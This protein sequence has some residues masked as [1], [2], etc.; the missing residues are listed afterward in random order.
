MI[1]IFLNMEGFETQEPFMQKRI[2]LEH[3]MIKYV[4][5]KKHI[6]PLDS[7]LN[8]ANISRQD[9]ELG[10][11]LQAVANN[12]VVSFAHQE[13]YNIRGISESTHLKTIIYCNPF[14]IAKWIKRAEGKDN[15][16]SFDY[17]SQDAR[18]AMIQELDENITYIKKI[19]NN[20]GSI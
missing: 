11:L 10:H 2:L 3:V 4:I 20:A 19:I 9:S 15:I 13:L 16:H 1:D 8:T 18:N 12:N 6:V 5:E 7:I 14:F 17:A